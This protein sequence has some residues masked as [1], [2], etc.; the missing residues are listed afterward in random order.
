M[1]VTLFAVALCAASLAIRWRAWAVPGEMGASLAVLF[2]GLGSFLISEASPFGEPLWRATGYGYL[3]DFAGHLL[4]LAGIVALLDQALYRLA[5]DFERTEIFDSLVRWPLSLIVPLMC[6]S[7][8]MSN[9]LHAEPLV[10]VTLLQSG[11]SVWLYAYRAVW[12][13]GLLYLTLLLIRVL[14][15]VR[16]TGEGSQWVTHAFL[17]AAGLTVLG[18]AFRLAAFW[19]TFAAL[20]DVPVFLR[21]AATATVALAAAGSWLGKMRDARKLLRLTRTSRRA[22]RRDTLESH[23]LR[24]LLAAESIIDQALDDTEAQRDEGPP[25]ATTQPAS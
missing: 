21:C 9:A 11:S 16:D 2:L 20:R 3:D 4:W 15:V 5:D 14:R 10:D 19:D 8:Y 22:R 24:V 13:G 17:A 25:A 7:M 18:L 12:Y 1:C 23:R 6:S